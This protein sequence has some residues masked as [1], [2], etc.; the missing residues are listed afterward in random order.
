MK[1]IRLVHGC[2]IEYICA[3]LKIE[4]EHYIAIEE[5]KVFNPDFGIVCWIFLCMKVEIDESD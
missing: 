4:L 3:I 2:K 5:N 1:N